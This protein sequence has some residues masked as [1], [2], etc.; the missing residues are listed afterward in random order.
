MPTRNPPRHGPNLFRSYL[1]IHNSVLA[2]YIAE[3]HF[4]G[5]EEFE[6]K[7]YSSRD[8]PGFLLEGSVG[9]LGEIIIEVAKF[10]EI[11]RE[12]PVPKNP[13]VETRWYKYHAFIRGHRTI[14]RY[15]NQDPDYLRGGH[16]DEHHKHVHDP[17][18]G[19]QLPESPIWVGAEGW[20]VFHEVIEEAKRWYWKNRD[21]LPNP[22]AF[23][24]LGLRS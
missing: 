14:F 21:L 6:V 23:P 2:R 24:K 17:K 7:P 22:N 3:G 19:E 12:G 1:E 11:V 15:D 20:P 16:I 8:R 5:K 9:C 10:L 13:Y 4:V 18:T